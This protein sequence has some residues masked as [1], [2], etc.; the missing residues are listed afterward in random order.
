MIHGGPV[1][2]SQELICGGRDPSGDQ[3]MRVFA[4][5]THSSEMTIEVIWRSGK[6]SVV[7]G[8]EAN[9]IYEV[10]EAA[11]A[12]VQSS[13]SK[14]QSGQGSGVRG[15]SYWQRSVSLRPRARGRGPRTRATSI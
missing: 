3:A 2:Q 8:V 10:E 5:G 13:K 9:R 4:A 11:A 14:V 15:Q 7:K 1:E 6:R 12:E